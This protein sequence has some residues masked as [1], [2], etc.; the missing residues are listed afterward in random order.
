MI[1]IIRVLRQFSQTHSIP[2]FIGKV[3]DGKLFHPT[4]CPTTPISRTASN[5]TINLGSRLADDLV[6]L[7]VKGYVRSSD[8][9]GKSSCL[10]ERQ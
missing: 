8:S 1:I 5:H 4:S 6:E 10:P 7:L 2:V 9:V 3:T